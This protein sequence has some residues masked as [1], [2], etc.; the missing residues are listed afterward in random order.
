MG[1]VRNKDIWR[2]MDTQL[3]LLRPDLL[4]FCM[5]ITLPSQLSPLADLRRER[6]PLRLSC[7]ARGRRVP[8]M[9]SM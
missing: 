2:T 6:Q 8:V 7:I 5:F 4:C 3:F 9:S 1:G